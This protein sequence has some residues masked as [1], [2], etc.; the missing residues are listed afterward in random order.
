MNRNF[1]DMRSWRAAGVTAS[2]L[3]LS[4]VAVASLAAP[5]AAQQ[6]VWVEEQEEGPIYTPYYDPAKID[7]GLDEEYDTYDPDGYDFVQEEEYEDADAINETPAPAGPHSN[8][9]WQK[10]LRYSDIDAANAYESRTIRQRPLL[11]DMPDP[12]VADQH[13]PVP[14]VLER[15]DR[16]SE[17]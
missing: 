3:W 14:E 9:V 4:L 16:T 17:R 13:P 5:T 2:R 10:R 15:N 8:R 6:R 11:G 1:S 7:I 12:Y